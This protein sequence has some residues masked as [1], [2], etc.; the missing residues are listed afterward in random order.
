M[1]P[2]I[3]AVL[4]LAAPPAFA[5][6]TD[7]I[8]R[9]QRQQPGHQL[10]IVERPPAITTAAAIASAPRRPIRA[11][12]PP[13]TTHAAMSR[14][15]RRGR[16]DENPRFARSRHCFQGC[17]SIATTCLSFTPANGSL[18]AKVMS[19]PNPEAIRSGL[20][21]R[22]HYGRNRDPNPGFEIDEHLAKNDAGIR[23]TLARCKPC[24]AFNTRRCRCARSWA[25]KSMNVPKT[26]GRAM[27]SDI[28]GMSPFPLSKATTSMAIP[29]RSPSSAKKHTRDFTNI[30]TRACGG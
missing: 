12:P 8:L 26:C 6:R 1:K 25:K 16:A 7:P 5:P 9:R 24:I 30:Q 28:V 2:L 18:A 21:A 10:D 19:K 4:L 27:A 11:A 20:R 15:E 3:T 17:W 23:T 14:V 13:T 29:R 22:I